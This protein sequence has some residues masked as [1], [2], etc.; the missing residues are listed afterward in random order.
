MNSLS[1]KLIGT[2][3]FALLCLFCQ[4]QN[5]VQ[6]PSFEKF[7]Q[8]PVKLGNLN[9]DVVQWSTPTLGSTDYFHSCSIHMGTPKNFNGEQ[10]AKFGSGYSGLY[11]Y[12]PDDYREYLQGELIGTLEKGKQY[13]L[14]F[15]IS[16]AER[17]DFAIREFGVLFTDNPLKFE[18]KRNISR[19]VRYSEANNRYHYLRIP[20]SEF[21]RDT[22]DWVEVRTTFEAKGTERFMILGNFE[23]NA[24]TLTTKRKRLARQGAYY[25]LDRV[26]LSSPGK[27]GTVTEASVPIEDEVAYEL[28]EEHTFKNVLFAFD[29]YHLDSEAR[30]EVLTVYNYLAKHPT[31]QI[32]VHGHTD[33]VGT[34]TYN[35]RLSERRSEAVARE[36]RRLG[37][38]KSR[39]SWSGKGGREPLASNDSEEGRQENRRVSFFLSNE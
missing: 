8:C 6:N 29:E 13:E 2:F 7:E 22:Q 31:Y 28:G 11:L 17:S 21:F 10:A 19:K 39:I 3:T 1:T 18:T 9:T 16:L 15:F 25:Y 27:S 23:N 20:D 30:E 35:Q 24:A 37:L 26:S 5:L 14:S 32:T 33:N 12:A 38:P 34:A 36:L 4:A